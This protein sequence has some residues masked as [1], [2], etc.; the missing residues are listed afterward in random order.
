MPAPLDVGDLTGKT[1]ATAVPKQ[2]K[3]NYSAD[4]ARFIAAIVVAM[5]DEKTQ[6]DVEKAVEI[7]KTREK[8][9]ITADIARRYKAAR[10]EYL[11]A[12]NQER[13]GH[14]EALSHDP[15]HR[16]VSQLK[17]GLEGNPVY[18]RYFGS[19]DPEKMKGKNVIP[20]W[21]DDYDEIFADFD[22]SDYSKRQ[23]SKELESYLK[24]SIKDGDNRPIA[25]R[26][27]IAGEHWDISIE[28]TVKH[29]LREH[30]ENEEKRIGEELRN[31]KKIGWMSL[32]AGMLLLAG[33]KA[34]ERYAPDAYFSQVLAE[35][36]YVAGLVLGFWGAEQKL[37]VE[38]P[39]KIKEMSQYTRMKKAE[40]FFEQY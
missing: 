15:Y 24:D 19:F 35:Y 36:T 18:S 34:I 26:F 30:F 28:E 13:A 39:R 12:K 37:L 25:I 29:R 3:P 33:Y 4:E 31:T 10:E 38:T 32:G 11:D 1:G 9:E 27:Q 6:G 23:V 21:I 22:S 7:L 40:I 20:R 2:K 16:A 17:E 8:P 5:G 14:T